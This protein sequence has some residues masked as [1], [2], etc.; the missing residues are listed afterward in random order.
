MNDPDGTPIDRRALKALAESLRAFLGPDL[1]VEAA[2]AR[3]SGATDAPALDILEGFPLLDQWLAA[4]DE[5]REPPNGHLMLKL[6]MVASII[7]DGLKLS[8]SAEW[9]RKL[10][11]HA[12][13]PEDRPFYDTL[14]E[15]EFAMFWANHVVRVSG[16]AAF[17]PPSGHPDL[18]L[19][20]VTQLGPLKLPAECKRIAP[21]G[22]KDSGRDAFA[23]AMDERVRALIS[24]YHPIKC[25]IWLHR[26]VSVE[27]VSAVTDLV[28]RLV[29]ASAK[30]EHWLTGCDP[31]GE[32]Q[33][34]VCALGEVG[35][36]GTRTISIQDVEV[37]GSVHASAEIDRREDG[38]IHRLKS[39]L[40]VR[41]D[42]PSDRLGSLRKRFR[43]AVLDQLP[44]ADGGAPGVVAL[45]IRKPQAMGDL[46]EVDRIVRAEMERGDP[47]HIALAALLWN[48]GERLA[49]AIEVD[50]EP[51]TEKLLAYHLRAYYVANGRSPLQVGLDSYAHYFGEQGRAV[52]RDPIDGTVKPVDDDTM[53]ILRDGGDIPPALQEAVKDL[54]EL[55]PGQGTTTHYVKSSMPWGELKTEELMCVLRAGPRQFRSFRDTGL[56]LRTIDIVDGIPRRICTI[57]LRAWAHLTELCTILRWTSD[58][59]TVGIW[60][61]DETELLEVVATDLPGVPAA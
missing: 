44:R 38:D 20:V 43:K 21:R 48:E 9:R 41:S 40:S 42:V 27:D 11:S 23:K 46:L 33:V 35:E 59:L 61:P 50:G 15:G 58:S 36:F 17:G 8:N 60:S 47:R 53:A 32:V 14:F 51:A 16:A 26:H 28:E 10:I 4:L 30:T 6:A 45:R 5:S 18:W 39:I 22:E 34:S 24:D 29:A 13:L 56:H 1:I 19:S 12:F 3:A 31:A 25:V 54:G 57:D 52:I 7:R 2:R 37:K 49:E 55:D